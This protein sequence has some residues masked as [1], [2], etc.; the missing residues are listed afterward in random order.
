MGNKNSNK[1]I[2]ILYNEEKFSIDFH[3]LDTIKNIKETIFLKKNFASD[4]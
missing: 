1:I 4:L 3:Q 2:Y